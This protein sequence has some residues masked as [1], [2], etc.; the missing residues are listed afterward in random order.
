MVHPWIL[1]PLTLIHRF[2]STLTTARGHI[3]L[4]A[5]SPSMEVTTMSPSPASPTEGNNLCEI[6]VTNVAIHSVTLLICLCGLAGNGAVL[7]LFSTSRCTNLLA[8]LTA[9]HL[10]FLLFT[11]PST[12]PYLVNDVFCSTLVPPMYLNL[13]FQLSLFSCQSE[14]FC[15]VF[16]SIER[17]QESIDLRLWCPFHQYQHQ[18][19]VIIRPLLWAL[20]YVVIAVILMVDFLCLFQGKCL[21]VH[22]SLYILTCLLFVASLFIS[23]AVIYVMANFY[24][25]Q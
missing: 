14:L 4:L 23:T 8:D 22:M 24:N 6:D 9:A 16:I 18:L 1:Q 12:L 20:F 25:Q 21:V 3:P 17:Y 7:S 19:R 5:Q 13:L 11:V 15:R 10:L 2:P